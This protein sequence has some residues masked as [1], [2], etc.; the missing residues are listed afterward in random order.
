VQVLEWQTS[1][2]PSLSSIIFSPFFFL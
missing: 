1:S 2:F